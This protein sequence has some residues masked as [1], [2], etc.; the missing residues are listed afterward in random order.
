[1]NI[2]VAAQRQR[3][4]RGLRIEHTDAAAIASID[5]TAAVPVDVRL[6]TTNT[7]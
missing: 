6:H 5:R 2:Q 1:M 4:G 7:R 3:D